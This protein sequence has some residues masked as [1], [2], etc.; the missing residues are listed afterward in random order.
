MDAKGQFHELFAFTLP[1]DQWT[2][3]QAKVAPAGK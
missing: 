1:F 3:A 2:A